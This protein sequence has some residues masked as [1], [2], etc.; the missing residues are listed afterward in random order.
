MR[1][2]PR[3]RQL[4]TPMAMLTGAAV[5]AGVLAIPVSLPLAFADDQHDLEKQQRSVRGAIADKAGDLEESSAEVSSTGAALLAAQAQLSDARGRLLSVQSQLEAARGVESQ[6]S[7]KLAETQQSLVV[8]QQQL[9]T[10]RAASAAQRDEVAD[11]I[12]SIYQQGDPQVLAIASVLDAQT[13]ADITRQ[14]GFSNVVVGKEDTAYDDLRAAGRRLARAERQVEQAEADVTAQRDQ[15]VE[16]INQIESLR[17]QAEDTESEV[18]TLV[19]TR[20]EARRSAKSAQAADEAALAELRAQNADIKKQILRAK[21]IA[22]RRAA[23][24]AAAAAAANQPA[25]TT[26]GLVGGQ[27][28]A[29]VDGR[30]T[31]PFGYRV[32][33]IFGYWGLHDGTDFGVACGEP[34]RAAGTGTVLSTYY[35]SSYGNR[36]FLD[37]GLV[38]GKA[39]TVVYNH[40]SGYAVSPGDTVAQGATV[41]Y[42]GSTG[43]ST[44]CH[45][46]FT[47]LEDGEPVDPMTYL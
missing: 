7:A 40:L 20:R 14:L 17:T 3:A 45:L 21:K 16:T 12:V 5:L 23:A 19:V 6:L 28:L 33:P 2:F 32:H 37:L 13:P 38:D 34:L 8:A 26:N 9:A 22:E 43:W 11:T 46:H 36:L 44:G 41:G 35:S 47:V 15:A 27:L 39:L 4:A 1:L 25:P 31:S 24:A 18:A 10:G 30:I 42:V 29:P